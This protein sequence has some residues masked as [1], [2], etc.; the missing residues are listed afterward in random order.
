MVRTLN[1][2]LVSHRAV[3]QPLRQADKHTL[4]QIVRYT[5]TQMSGGQTDVQ[6]DRQIGRVKI[7]LRLQT[8]QRS[9]SMLTCMRD[10]TV[11]LQTGQRSCSILTWMRSSCGRCCRF[12]R[13]W[14]KLL[15]TWQ[16]LAGAHLGG[17]DVHLLNIPHHPGPRSLVLGVPIH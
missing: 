16:T 10:A 7:K 6:I 15:S 2:H 1:L 11:D 3:F 12:G 8:K 13:P 5:S 9:C 4:R 17:M 14:Q